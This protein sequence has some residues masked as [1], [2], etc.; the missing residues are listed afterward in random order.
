MGQ[1][2]RNLIAKAAFG[3]EW[4][5]LRLYGRNTK[6]LSQQG[7]T[8]VYL[9]T[10]GCRKDQNRYKISWADATVD[11]PKDGNWDLEQILRNRKLTFGQTLWLRAKDYQRR[12]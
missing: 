3:A 7:L 9:D 11:L 6:S 8:L 2:E 5:H 1:I 4:A 12:K 10:E